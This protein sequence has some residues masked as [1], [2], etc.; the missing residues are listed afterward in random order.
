MVWVAKKVRSTR[1][2]VASHAVAFAPF[3]QNSAWIRSP[4]AESGHA[5]PGQSKPPTWLIFNSV[6]A[7]RATPI[8]SKAYFV[9]WRTPRMPTDVVLGALTWICSSDSFATQHSR[10]FR[11]RSATRATPHVGPSYVATLDDFPRGSPRHRD[12][13][14]ACRPPDKPAT[15]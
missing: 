7:L 1:E 2:R 15:T 3:S 14:C 4:G 10:T 6:D 9:A 11:R 8:S 12:E 5:Q 13:N